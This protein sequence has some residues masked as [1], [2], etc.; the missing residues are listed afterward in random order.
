MS[1]LPKRPIA[2]NA[3]EHEIQQAFFIAA[4][5]TAEAFKKFALALMTPIGLGHSSGQRHF[6]EGINLAAEQCAAYAND[7][8][9]FQQKNI[10][11]TTQHD[12]TRDTS[13][14]GQDRR[15]H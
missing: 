12:Y 11:E 9:E 4:L 10:K 1:E 7:I 8:I 15:H 5:Q 3:V 2:T 13:G 6:I 14:N